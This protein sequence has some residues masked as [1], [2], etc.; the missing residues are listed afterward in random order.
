MKSVR[1]GARDGRVMNNLGRYG[2]RQ[3]YRRT[4]WKRRSGGSLYIRSLGVHDYVFIP[5]RISEKKIPSSG[6]ST[7][8]D[9]RSRGTH[10]SRL[11]LYGLMRL[12]WSFAYIPGSEKIALSTGNKENWVGNFII[13][14]N[15][16]HCSS[17][18]DITRTKHLNSV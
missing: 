17:T 9:A 10:T 14:P 15:F 5:G 13:Q 12:R 7:A 6:F 1:R 11:F 2:G 18:Y 8:R 3:K 4:A 16:H